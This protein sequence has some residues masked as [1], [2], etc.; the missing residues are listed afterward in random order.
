MGSQKTASPSS[1]KK[2]K[3]K[4][5]PTPRDL[6][7][8]AVPIDANSVVQSVSG[9]VGTVSGVAGMVTSNVNKN[10]RRGVDV[11]P[12][13]HHAAG[14]V[15]NAALSRRSVKFTNHRSSG[16]VLVGRGLNPFGRLPI[17]DDAANVAPVQPV[18]NIP[19]EAVAQDAG[20]AA[21]A[22]VPASQPVMQ[23][24][25]VPSVVGAILLTEIEK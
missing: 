6:G 3:N 4:K 17:V 2:P 1:A 12:T 5:K 24:A 13:V 20:N 10:G 8:D 9:A 22:S 25:G 11:V 7:A 14:T 16:S 18:N 23:G 21:P 19:V 15:K